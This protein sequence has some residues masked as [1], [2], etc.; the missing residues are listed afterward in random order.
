MTS[1]RIDHAL[2]DAWR[3]GDRDWPHAADE[4]VE[5]HNATLTPCPRRFLRSR[6]N[7]RYFRAVF[8][9]D[10]LICNRCHHYRVTSESTV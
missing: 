4:I 8:G 9:R 7:W 2:R 10:L 3:K 5:R 6:H 1:D